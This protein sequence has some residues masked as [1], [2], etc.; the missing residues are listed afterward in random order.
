MSNTRYTIEV[1]GLVIDEAN[2]MSN[3]LE[4]ARQEARNYGV[5]VNVFAH[6]TTRSIVV[7]TVDVNG[8]VDMV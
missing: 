8:K 7:A 1:S 3:A 6:K 4:L 2:K 5:S